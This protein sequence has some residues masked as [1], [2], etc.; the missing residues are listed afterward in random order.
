[1]R[2]E[3]REYDLVP[4]VRTIVHG[5]GLLRSLSYEHGTLVMIRDTHICAQVHFLGWAE[6]WDQVFERSSDEL[7]KLHTFTTPWRQVRTGSKKEKMIS[8][9]SDLCVVHEGERQTRRRLRWGGGG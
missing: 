5:H 2:P 8:T 9:Q 3:E 6:K 7:Q 4:T 1:M